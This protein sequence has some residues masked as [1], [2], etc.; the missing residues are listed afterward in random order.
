MKQNFQKDKIF[1]EKGEK[2]RFI[3]Q[4]EIGLNK[5]I[6]KIREKYKVKIFRSD[7]EEIVLIEALDIPD[8]KD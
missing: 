1:I 7:H 5:I 2:I 6:D 8:E 3:I 4:Q